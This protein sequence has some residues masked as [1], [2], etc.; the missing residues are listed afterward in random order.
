MPI[1]P[2]DKDLTDFLV[3]RVGSV[4]RLE[5]L[6]YLHDHAARAFSDEELAVELRSGRGMARDS[7]RALADIGVVELDSDRRARYRP[8]TPALDQLLQRLKSA[9]QTRPVSVLDAIYSAPP[10]AIR[11]FADAFKLK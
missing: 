3:D 10:R 5:L 11:S 4:H 1:E 8:A 2:L 6:L 9:Y 7:L